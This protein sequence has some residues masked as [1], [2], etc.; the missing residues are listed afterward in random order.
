MKITCPHCHTTYEL[1]S[2]T[3]GLEGRSVR[4]TR[5]Q[6]VWHAIDEE[7]MDAVQI[8]VDDYE[9]DSL[10]NDTPY[11]QLENAIHT[12]SEQSNTHNN[13]LESENNTEQQDVDADDQTTTLA[14]YK[15]GAFALQTLEARANTPTT[16][17]H[18]HRHMRA[19]LRYGHHIFKMWP[20][21]KRTTTLIA[22]ITGFILLISAFPLRE[23]IVRI[24]PSTSILYN[25]VGL[26]INLYGLDF[27]NI[28]TSRELRNGIITLVIE[29]HIVNI[30]EHSVTVPK[31]RI[32]L[33]NRAHYELH[34]WLAKAKEPFLIAGGTTSFKTSLTAPPEIATRLELALAKST[35]KADKTIP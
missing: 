1:A 31:I 28:K 25:F 34:S 29:G 7:A 10:E 30:S 22:T 33:Q 32:A 3:I 17:E 24:F 35:G 26:N 20:F 18:Q 21:T 23:S 12:V 6:T 13:V 11:D 15:G 2:K 5:C 14:Q 9:N 19:H 27:H 4:C 8:E 16:A